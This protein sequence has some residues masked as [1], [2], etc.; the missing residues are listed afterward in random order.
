LKEYPGTRM[1]GPDGSTLCNTG[2]RPCGERSL[3]FGD[4]A[5]FPSG[6]A[7]SWTQ[8]PGPPTYYWVSTDSGNAYIYTKTTARGYLLILLNRFLNDLPG[9]GRIGALIWRMPV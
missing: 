7:A 1:L 9:G 4:Y 3:W 8:L 6:Q 5:T 2:K